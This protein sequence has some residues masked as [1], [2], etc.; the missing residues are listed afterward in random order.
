MALTKE[1]LTLLIALQERDG[2]LD[3]LK[4]QMEAVPRETG[5]LRERLDGEKGALSQAKARLQG[6]EKKKKEK[7]LE[8]FQKEEAVRK[9]SMELNQVKT[10]DAFKA[11]QLEIEQAR[12]EGGDIETEILQIMEDL[13]VCRKEEKS[14]QSEFGHKEK[15]FNAQIAVLEA[16]FT[17]VKGR[18]DAA[19]AQRDQLAVPLPAEMLRVY[20]HI[21]SR[22]KP[23]AVVPIEGELCSACRISLA[24]QVIVEAIKAKQLVTC[25][26]CLR[27]LYR[28]QAIAARAV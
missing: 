10:N 26:N 5:L 21:R 14:L 18:F 1:D 4:S 19:K 24:P 3:K 6:L 23:D 13:D 11:L 20:E 8:L 7:E 28:P 17:E 22:G 2:A 15:E 9:H 25:E 12:S 16:R 27:I